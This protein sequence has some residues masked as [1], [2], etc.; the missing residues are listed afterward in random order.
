MAGLL[1]ASQVL[2]PAPVW[3]VLGCGAIVLALTWYLLVKVRDWRPRGSPPAT[4]LVLILIFASLFLGAARYQASQPVIDA[5]HIAWYN[6]REYDLLITGTLENPPD[7]RDSYTNLHLKVTGVDTGNGYDFP[8]EGTILARV[9]AGEEYQYGE[10]LRLRGRLQT[11]PEDEEFSYRDYLARQGIHAY[12]TSA[13]VTRLP[14]DSGNPVLAAIYAIKDR[15]LKVIYQIFPDPEASLLAGILLGVDTGLPPDLQQA[16]KNT[17]TAH[18][19][20]ISGFNIA[21]LSGIFVSLFGRIFGPRRG[22]LVAI[23]G[24]AL[25]TILVGAEAAVVRAAFMGTLSLFA[26]QVGRRQHGLN[27]LGFTA[28]LMAVFNPYVPWDVGFQL[29]FGATLGLILYAQPFQQAAENFLA[30][31]MPAETASKVAA[32]IAE[33]FLFTLAAQLTTLPIMAWHFGRISIISLVANPFILPA[34]PPVMILGGLALLFSLA[35]LPL[36]RAVAFLAWPFPAYTIRAVELFDRFPGGVLVLDN[37]PFWYIILFYAILLGITFFGDRMKRLRA[38]ITP[39]VILSALGILVIVVWQAVAMLPDGNLHLT[40]LDVGSANAIL[41]QTPSGRAVLVNGGP[42]TTQLSDALGRRISPFHRRLD[43]LVVASLQEE[44][45]AA[46]PRT[47][48]HYP[49]EAA[50][51][52]GNMAASYASRQLDDFLSDN[53]IPIT[54][55]AAG[56]TLD[57]GSGAVLQIV[58]ASPRGAILLLEWGGFRALLPIGMDFDSLESFD[59][60][61]AIGPVTALL[62]ADSGYA[63]V[64]PPEWIA[65]LNP[66]VLILSVDAADPF[67]LPDDDTLE[68]AAPYTLLRTDLNGWIHLETDG[69]QL[70]IEAERK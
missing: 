45:L 69:E 35:Y 20:A 8:V 50:L 11:P 27:T 17:G 67:G 18:I 63:P 28:A 48:E 31:R 70:W 12:M 64:N 9:E 34:Q 19:I 62:L 52:A 56:Y 22:V 40:F 68:A 51:W 46:L 36:G 59:Y 39:A 53:N 26:R 1:L 60:G 49:P 7:Y 3:V 61:E 33:Y 58:D 13:T 37:F 42:S 54:R 44:Q 5:F 43:Y 47:L 55:A 29:S 66:Q 32:P 25:Y 24:I 10:R 4:G 6:D 30:R 16:F 23:I 38:L 15:S 21:I 41:I 57:L 65:N 14:G 2:L